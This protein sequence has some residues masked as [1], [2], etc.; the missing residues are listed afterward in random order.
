MTV[1][2]VEYKHPP[3]DSTP[4]NQ[5]IDEL[6]K[7]YNL[8]DNLKILKCL[9]P[10]AELLYNESPSTYKNLLCSPANDDGSFPNFDIT[11][12]AL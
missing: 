12:C 10:Y 8:G 2:D 7:N 3:T 11:L 9:L 6:I 1:A 4:S 5:F